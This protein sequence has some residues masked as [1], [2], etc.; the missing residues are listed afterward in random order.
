MHPEFAIL[1]CSRMSGNCW[2]IAEAVWPA[3]P[4]HAGGRCRQP[5]M[6]CYPSWSAEGLQWGNG[7]DGIKFG[8]HRIVYMFTT[9]V[10]YTT[11]HSVHW[12]I[13]QYTNIVN[14]L[15]HTHKNR[16]CTRSKLL[17]TSDNVVVV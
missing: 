9:F 11:K 5:Q 13:N 2:S 16:S 10:A 1:T 12:T 3:V 4:G 15:M 17:Y 6:T 7:V 14:V 8:K